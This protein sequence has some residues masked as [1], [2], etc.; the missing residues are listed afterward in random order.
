MHLTRFN[1]LYI[2]SFSCCI[3]YSLLTYKNT[4]Y[5]NT[6]AAKC[7]EGEESIARPGDQELDRTSILCYTV[8]IRE[9]M[10]EKRDL[11]I[12]FL[13]GLLYNIYDGKIHCTDI[14]V[15]TWFSKYKMG[16]KRIKINA[17]YIHPYTNNWLI[18][19]TSWFVEKSIY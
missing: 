17:T 6:V 12:F 4:E 18:N 5:S 8:C 1:L 16:S 10:W 14:K 3:S 15:V 7:F 19:M 2:R 13:F 9:T 11:N